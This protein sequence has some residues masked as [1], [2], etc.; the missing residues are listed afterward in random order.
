MKMT[1]IPFTIDMTTDVID[2]NPTSKARKSLH[3]QL[4]EFGSLIFSA[5]PRISVLLAV[6]LS[7]FPATAPRYLDLNAVLN[8][9]EGEVSDEFLLPGDMASRL[10]ARKE[11]SPPIPKKQSET[12][13]LGVA[14]SRS[15]PRATTERQRQ[16]SSKVSPDVSVESL[17]AASSIEE[18]VDHVTD[19]IQSKLR[20]DDLLVVWLLDATRSMANDRRHM[21]T[22]LELY[23]QHFARGVNSRHQLRNAVVSFGATIKERVT[24]TDSQDTI[25][26]SVREFPNDASGKENVFTAIER[27]AANYRKKW[28]ER[29]LMI[30]VWTDESGDDVRKLENTIRV[31][32]DHDVAVTVIGASAVL[33]AARGLQSFGDSYPRQPLQLPVKRGPD[34]ALPERLELGYWFLTQEPPSKL[35]SR[36]GFGERKMPPWYGNNDETVPDHECVAA[37]QVTLPSWYGGGHLNGLV[38]GISPYALTRL[39]LQTGGTYILLDRNDE[40][41]PFSVDAMRAYLPDYR[42]I[43]EYLHEVRTHPLRRAVMGAVKVTQNKNLGPPPTIL[44]GNL[45]ESPPYGF[46]RA[47]FTPKKFTSNLHTSRRWLK[48][49]ADRTSR[50]VEQALVHVSESGSVENG[51]EH[52]YEGEESRRWRAWYD[53]TRGRLLATSVRLEEYRLTCD[54]VVTAGFLNQT[55]NH[56]IFVP[57]REMKSNSNFRRRAEEAERL[58]MRCVRENPN[59]AWAWLAQRELDYALGINVRQHALTRVVMPLSS[60]SRRPYFPKL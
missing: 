40:R 44:F 48:A 41:G 49:H 60:A 11:V 30:V 5:V 27:C 3:I 32:Q 57:T 37:T 33:G 21:A 36:G 17:F 47:Y 12:R 54:L 45:S 51:L 16:A 14:L 28:R 29:Q 7:L 50:F 59:T 1:A 6:T 56:V 22:Q 23:I 10:P 2:V 43:E 46:M 31:C 24:P 20:E 58:L 9:G 13:A 34:S 15:D 19:S 53:L 39:T 8:A 4:W 26:S 38:S 55:T 52:E 25:P 42:S 35:D 18:A